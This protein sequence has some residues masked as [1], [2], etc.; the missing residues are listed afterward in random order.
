MNNIFI[1]SH[2]LSL[3]NISHT[4]FQKS[5]QIRVLNNINLDISHGEIIALTG[6]SGTGKSTLLNIAG[7]IETPTLGSINLCDTDCRLINEDQKTIL[8]G[9]NIGFIFQSHRLFPEFSSLENVMLPQLLMGLSKK[10]ALSNSKELLSTLGLE[11]RFLFRPA[12]LS[13]GEAQRV[14][15]AR[16]LANSPNLILAD[17][18]TGNLDPETAKKVFELLYKLVRALNISCLVATHNVDLANSMDRRIS[19]KYGSIIS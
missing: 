9:K 2:V 10:Q 12:N 3:K 7:L 18:P 4:Y 16:A 17:E 13:G 1:Q 11:D 8:R 15:I 5:N 19:L 14:A 6:P